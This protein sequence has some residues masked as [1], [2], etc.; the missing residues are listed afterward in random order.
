MSDA[1]ANPSAAPWRDAVGGL[2]D[3]IGRLQFDFLVS[4]GLEPQHTFLDVGCG[5]FRGGVHLIKYLEDGRY[6]GIDAQQ[7][8]LDAA[9][10]E[11]VPRYS[12]AGRTFQ[13]LCRDDFD[14]TAFGTTFDYC[15]ALSIFTH[16]PWNVILRCL[17]NM[18]T[19]L[20]PRGRFYA[21]FFEDPDGSHLVTSLSHAPGG[22]VTFPDRDPFHYSVDVFEELGRRTH[23]DVTYIGDWHHP[24]AQ[25]MMLFTPKSSAGVFHHDAPPSTRGVRSLAKPEVGWRGVPGTAEEEILSGL[26]PYLDV[27]ARFHQTL[28]PASY[29]EVGVRHG[30]SLALARCPAVGV[31]P[32]P[33]IDIELPASAVVATRASD[34][35][36]AAL[37]FDYVA[38]FA[39]IDGLHLF[40]QALR[41]FMNV[42][43]VAR[44]GATLLVDDILPNHSAQAERVRRTRAWTGDVWKLAL[45]LKAYRPELLLAALDTHPAGMLLVSG[46]D[47][48]NRVLWDEYNRIVREFAGERP[49]PAEVLARH[50]ALDP[51]SRE[52]SLLLQTLA[53]TYRK[54]PEP[55]VVAERLRSDTRKIAVHAPKLSVVIIGYNMARELPRTIQSFSPSMQRG[56]ASSDYEL[57]VI[58]NGSTHPFDEAEL[59]RLAPNLTVQYMQ[60]ATVSPVPAI[61]VG[62]ERARGELVGVCIDG[63]RM[64]SPGLLAAAMTASKLHSK[65]VVGTLAFHLGKEAQ[66]LSVRKGYDQAA[67]DAMLAQSNWEQ[68]G[69]RLFEISTFAGSSSEG[70]FETPAESN[71]IFMQAEHWRE[72]GG[73]DPAFVTPGGGLA[74]LDIW[75]R[76]CEDPCAELIMLLGEATF[77]QVHGGVATN[78]PVTKW[79]L[80]HEE[81]VR[82]RRKPFRKPARKPLLVGKFRAGSPAR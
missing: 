54:P 48:T 12:L 76:A 53:E 55:D 43:R 22:V 34:E 80:F 39:F 15:L 11:E 69:Y 40:E 44:P 24:R 19:V 41:D 8:L 79:D 64:A 70:W 75:V 29:L 78:S 77:H 3:E 28:Q 31:D 74:N 46:L 66:E 65:P 67:E 6:Y 7:W 14:F 33:E 20:K 18:H 35:F 58:D 82:L 47:P 71:A 52:F 4:E 17:W 37:P 32:F 72:L 59:L 61:N 42:E 63:A 51:N 25:K 27:L 16:Q 23:L 45:V 5:C 57:I 10:R 21:T 13:V 9:V 2:W 38:D 50:G 60:G 81:Y 56:I 36:F 1:A 73:Y 68:D 49:P 30:R 62:L 26:V